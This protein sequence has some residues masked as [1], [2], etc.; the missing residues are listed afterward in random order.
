M[1]TI[2]SDKLNSEHGF[3]CFYLKNT[4]F[5]FKIDLLERCKIG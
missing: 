3:C 5:N 2:L 1:F 4:C